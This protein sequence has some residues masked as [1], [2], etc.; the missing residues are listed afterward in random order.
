MFHKWLI[1]P[2]QNPIEIHN[3]RRD[4]MLCLEVLVLSWDWAQ[5]S[6]DK[7]IAVQVILK[8]IVLMLTR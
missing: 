6:R 8:F 5:I 7:S 2:I 3:H 4:S 1:N